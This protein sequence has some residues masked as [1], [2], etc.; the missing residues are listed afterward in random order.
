MGWTFSG[1]REP[2]AALQAS[3]AVRHPSQ[4]SIPPVHRE[5]LRRTGVAAL[6]HRERLRDVRQGAW[7]RA[8]RIFAFRDS[9]KMPQTVMK[10]AA[11]T[12][13]TTNPFSPKSWSPP[14][15]EMSTR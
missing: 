15:V 14:R 2:L 3:H 9:E 7:N 8:H 4:C 11:I 13:P 10:V 6:E 1:S 5:W 12:G